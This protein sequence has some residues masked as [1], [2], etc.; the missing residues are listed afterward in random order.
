MDKQVFTKLILA[1]WVLAK[2]SL[3]KAAMSRNS[4]QS[5][6]QVIHCCW[7]PNLWP[8][9]EAFTELS[10]AAPKLSWLLG[11]FFN[12]F[13]IPLAATSARIAGKLSS[14]VV[15][16][17][18]KLVSIPWASR[19]DVAGA[20]RKHISPHCRALIAHEQQWK[21][22]WWCSSVLSEL[23]TRRVLF[24]VLSGKETLS[25]DGDVP[26]TTCGCHTERSL[27][28][29]PV[30][31]TRFKIPGA[32]YL[33]QNMIALC[34]SGHR[35]FPLGATQLPLCTARE[36]GEPDNYSREQAPKVSPA[37]SNSG[38]NA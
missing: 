29:S 12:D 24:S 21:L 11:V 25:P 5:R 20:T 8:N 4:R 9:S 18:E 1:Y 19:G 23:P 16:Q 15:N 34:N 3:K 36:E 28:C 33:P 6:V 31:G 14:P 2:I 35:N 7:S 13:N 32:L 37:R 17:T 10:P 30:E 22:P 26:W 27:P 38:P